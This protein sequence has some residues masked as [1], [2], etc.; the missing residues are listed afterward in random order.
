MQSNC[1]VIQA[2]LFYRKLDWRVALQCLAGILVLTI[3]A[4]SLYRSASMYHP[5]RKVILHIKSQKKGRRDHEENSHAVAY[6]DFSALRM[7]SLQALM[8]ITGIVGLGIYVPF[9]V[10]V[11]QPRYHYVI[12]VDD[13]LSLDRWY[14]VQ[15]M[16]LTNSES[17]L[18]FTCGDEIKPTAHTL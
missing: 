9:V 7:R 16:E 4:G 14:D 6:F 18:H 13:V 15:N 12:R 11:I 3:F 10:M 5:R 2:Y 17:I 8:C 1:P